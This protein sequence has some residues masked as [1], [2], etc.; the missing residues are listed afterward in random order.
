MGFSMLS[1]NLTWR[2][3]ETGG[4]GNDRLILKC[5]KG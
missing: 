4:G 1:P 3:E 2:V 5:P